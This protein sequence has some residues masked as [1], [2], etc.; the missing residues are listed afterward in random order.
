[1]PL[2]PEPRAHR[3][4]DTQLLTELTSSPLNEPRPVKLPLKADGASV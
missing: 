3:T 4:S 1:V 2:I